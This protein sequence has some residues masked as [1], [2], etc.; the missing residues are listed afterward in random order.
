MAYQGQG[1]LPTIGGRMFATARFNDQNIADTFKKVLA[2]SGAPS[3]Q[4][5]QYF[6]GE[7]GTEYRTVTDIDPNQPGWGNRVPTG[8][9]LIG[10]QSPEMYTGKQLQ[11]YGNT[12]KTPGFAILRKKAE[13]KPEPVAPPPPPPP[14]PA[15][16]PEPPPAPVVDPGPSESDLAIK[17]LTDQ[18]SSMTTN[19]ETL[20]ADQAK[21]FDRIQTV[22]NDRIS[23]LRDLVSST[24]DQAAEQMRQAQMQFIAQLNRPTT[25]GVRT[26]T[27]SAGTPMQ[28]ARR[29]TTGTFG[30]TG[31]R[32]RSLNV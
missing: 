17:A 29:G 14:T 22:Q 25:A 3:L 2:Q 7:G 31:M 8:Y 16:A 10:Y 13:P 11:L 26:A 23:D 15:P 27:G 20:L 19:T 24:K 32:I 6:T 1:Y 18:I 12:P 5:G 21:E 9:E 28:I 30:R 4:A